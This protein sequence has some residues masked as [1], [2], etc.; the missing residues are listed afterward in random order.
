MGSEQDK[1]M[2]QVL[3]EKIGKVKSTGNFNCFIGTGRECKG[4]SWRSACLG[5]RKVGGEVLS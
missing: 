2:S 1:N 3:R 4:G 5:V